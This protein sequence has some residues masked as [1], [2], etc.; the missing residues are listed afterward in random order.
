M[1]DRTFESASIAR[2]MLEEEFDRSVPNRTSGFLTWVGVGGL[3]GSVFVVCGFLGALMGSRELMVRSQ[4]DPDGLAPIA[5]VVV[6][7]PEP[8]DPE[9][10]GA[11]TPPEPEPNREAEPVEP[12][13]EPQP[14]PEPK[15]PPPSVSKPTPKPPPAPEP[16][17]LDVETDDL[18]DPW[19]E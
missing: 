18:I 9:P 16:D 7:E 11:A 1:A 10:A 8:L 15:P 17:A 4:A 2:R 6:D 3:F 5:P 12:E 13:P 19:A 14:A